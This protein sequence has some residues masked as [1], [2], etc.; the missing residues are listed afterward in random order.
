MALREP[1]E[2]LSC[3]YRQILKQF[4]KRSLLHLLVATISH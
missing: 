2:S 3:I 1:K 4:Y